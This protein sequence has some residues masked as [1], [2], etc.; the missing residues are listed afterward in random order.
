VST[1]PGTSG[2]DDGPARELSPV[3]PSGGPTTEA[4][5][6]L[7]FTA[8][9]LVIA[10]IYAATSDGEWAGVALLGFAAVFS[11]TAGLWFLRLRPVQHDTEQLELEAQPGEAADPEAELYLPSTSVWPLGMGVGAALTLSGIAVGWP[12]LLPG[13][14][15]LGYSVIGLAHQSRNRDVG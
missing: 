5:V 15:L 13:A 12:L 6:F 9:Y 7:G 2:G 14:A 11:A 10:I 4:L 1:T 8:F 3:E